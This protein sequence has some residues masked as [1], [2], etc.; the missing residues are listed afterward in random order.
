M[1]KKII[2]FA[3]IS[4]TIPVSAMD[5]GQLY[6]QTQETIEKEEAGRE[7]QIP[8][9]KILLIS[10]DN[11]EFMVP[12][13]IAKQSETIKHTI[14]DVGTKIIPLA[15]ISGTLLKEV[16]D[17]LTALYEN[18]NLKGKKLL[19]T[20]EQKVTITVDPFEFLR[21]LNYLDIPDLLNL[22]ARKVAQQ[23]INKPKKTP[24]FAKKE[25]TLRKKLVQIAGVSAQDMLKIVAKYYFLISGTK[26][27]DVSENSY[28]CSILDWFS[29]KPELFSFHHRK[30]NLDNRN[31]NDL[32][33][34]DT[35]PS[36]ESVEEL[37]LNNNQITQI[38]SGFL[39]LN[40]LKVL[41][42]AKN[43]IAAIP[44]D[45]SLLKNL[46]ALYL[47]YNKIIHIPDS[48]FDL[49][50]LKLLYLDHNQITEISDRISQLQNL[51]NLDLSN[52]QI[53]RVPAVISQLLN[54]ES[55]NLSYNLIDR[56]NASIFL[57]MCPPTGHL[58]NIGLEGNKLT[59]AFVENLRKMVWIANLHI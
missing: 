28:A 51:V 1:I 14:E 54:L 33:G 6:R 38:P 10:S 5:I 22:A 20:L 17:L 11:Q 50:K 36:I 59:E 15:N 52:N 19:D 27:K 45:I 48:F 23:E 56:A 49:S 46:Y 9:D 35:I 32:E 21:A 34:I 3:L 37:Y 30:L 24:F 57:Q 7:A 39:H 40:N 18:R 12:V 31:I 41:G 53:R 4:I 44:Q 25:P 8:A 26:L 29:Y 47:S 58:I 43:Q 2:A 55:L 16:V 13:E 42:L